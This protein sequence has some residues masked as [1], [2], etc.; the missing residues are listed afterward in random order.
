MRGTPSRFPDTL[1]LIVGMIAV[2]WLLTYALPAGRFLREPAPSAGKPHADATLPSRIAAARSA[3]GMQVAELAALFQV[4]PDTVRGW[5][6]GAAAPVGDGA[7][8]PR[9]PH[10]E[11]RVGDL[12]TA[13]IT[14]G[15]PPTQKAIDAWKAGVDG[16]K[17]LVPDSYRPVPTASRLPWH[18]VFTAIPRGLEAAAE[19]IFFVFLIGGV[20]GI[21]RATGAFDALISAAIRGCGHNAYPLIIGTV[22]LFAVGSG[23]IGMA[24]EYVPFI[25][26]L[27][28][29]SLSL[30]LDAM[31]G[32]G[33][34]LVGY[35]VGYGC[36][37]VNPFTV[38]I[39]QGIAG[40]PSTSGWGFRVAVLVVCLAVG[41]QHLLAYARRVQ[42]DPSRSLVAD[43]DYS[44][45][46]ELPDD[47]ALTRARV[48]T[49]LAFATTVVVFV[50]GVS[51]YKWYLVELSAVFLGLGMLTP[52]L[53]R[54]SPN[55]AAGHFCSGAAELTTTALLIGF[56]RTIEV[57]LDD[58]QVIDTI[59]HG[60]ATGLGGFGKEAGALGMLAVQTLCN[61]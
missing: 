39:A 41:L 45:S 46:F 26:L 36:A 56:A 19:I 30:R 44:G 57:V 60:I 12:L 16:R 8:A 47:V 58:G 24:E 15:K 51:A 18:T 59:V 10:V 7:T 52:L 1:V 34:V 32:I 54:M 20:I 2:A 42:R 61:F 25:A 22:T 50:W 38:L 14:D 23:L 3:R 37:P 40:L 5:E 27:V 6:R 53:N 33:I 9:G 43:L 28:T 31:V 29:M 13:W 35:A 4:A 21:L 17:Q 55:A 48:L 11:A 49:L